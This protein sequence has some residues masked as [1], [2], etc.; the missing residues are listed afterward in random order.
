MCSNRFKWDCMVLKKMMMMRVVVNGKSEICL[1][2]T[3]E[4][5]LKHGD[6]GL[7]RYATQASVGCQVKN[8]SL[9]DKKK[10]EGNSHS[11]VEYLGK[12]RLLCFFIVV[13][14]NPWTDSNT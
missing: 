6:A 4:K 10:K 11:K 12:L 9:Q 1:H 7:Y 2:W 5:D 3:G 13:C 8:L 14:P